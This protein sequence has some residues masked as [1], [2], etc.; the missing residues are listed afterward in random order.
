MA[1]GIRAIIRLSAL[2]HNLDLVRQRAPAS[3]ILTV[4]KADAYGHGLVEVGHALQPFSD[5][6]GVAT[7]DEALRLKQSGIIRPI[8]LLQGVLSEEEL[9]LAA[10]QQFHLVVHQP[11]Q[12]DQ[13]LAANL[14]KP[15]SVW[16][17]VN[18][19]MN[20][21]GFPIDACLDS[22]HQLISSDRVENV[23]LMSH[24]ACMDEV[25]HD[26]N[27]HQQAQFQSLIERCGVTEAS[28]SNSAGVMR[29]P[30]SHF[31]WVRPG[32]MLYGGSPVLGTTASA[33]GLKAVMQLEA[34]IISRTR[35]LA[36]ETVGYG[37]TWQA[38]KNT[39]IAIVSIGYGD[40]YPRHM[41]SQAQ[42][43]IAGR[44][45]P[46]VGRVSMDML[47]VDVSNLPEAVPGAQVQLWG[48]D[49][50]IEQ[51]AEW[52]GTVNYELMCQ[53]SQRVPRIYQQEA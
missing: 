4:V 22:F 21:L 29:A 51:V 8:L 23:I 32:L 20:R 24:F 39:D 9:Q 34:R 26:L 2:K 15:V 47:A 10:E 36:G 50:P 31:Q 12:R 40:G 42:V 48:D 38:D 44:R 6:F 49:L 35:V 27:L 45:C 18:T 7:F 28:M 30:E 5:G 11:W 25:G 52:A 3:Q 14:S 19:G 16:L 13:L 46:L 33:L 1:R 17:K 37:A 53:V 41:S 43:S